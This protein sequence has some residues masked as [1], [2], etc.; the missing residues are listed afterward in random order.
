MKV[1]A[2]HPASGYELVKHINE[3]TGWKPS[4]GSMYPL[5]E[6]MN[7]KKLVSIKQEGRK[8]IYSLTVKGKKNISGWDEKKHELFD[9]MKEKVSDKQ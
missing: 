2:H 3:M 4:F 6:D 8:K 9:S 7:K 1:L 5:L